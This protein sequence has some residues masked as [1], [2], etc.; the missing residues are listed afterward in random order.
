MTGGQDAGTSLNHRYLLELSLSFVEQLLTL[1]RFG[2]EDLPAFSGMATLH[3]CFLPKL[4]GPGQECSRLR[5]GTSE[6]TGAGAE[7]GVPRL[8]SCGTP[9]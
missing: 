1:A 9:P 3:K 5:F 2:N 8:E 6:A 7:S 4:W